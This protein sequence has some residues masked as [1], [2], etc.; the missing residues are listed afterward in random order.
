MLVRSFPF[1]S[2]KGLARDV[3]DVFA[4]RVDLVYDVTRQT[5]EHSRRSFFTKQ[6]F[7]PNR[8]FSENKAFHRTG[9]FHDTRRFH[10]TG[11]FHK[12]GRI[13]E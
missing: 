1:K 13:I 6:D 4:S 5:A 10:D 2:R 9:R 12:S 3:V 8:T 7:S 11:R